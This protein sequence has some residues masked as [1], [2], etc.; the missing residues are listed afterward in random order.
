MLIRR[1]SAF[2]RHCQSRIWSKS[3]W[4]CSVFPW[5]ELTCLQFGHWS[6]MLSRCWRMMDQLRVLRMRLWSFLNQLY[7]LLGHWTERFLQS[8][9]KPVIVLEL[10]ENV[11]ARFECIFLLCLILG[12]L[13]AGKLNISA[14]MFTDY[15]F[16][17]K[18]VASSKQSSLIS[19]TDFLPL[20]KEL[21]A[22]LC[23]HH[24][25]KRRRRPAPVESSANHDWTVSAQ[26]ACQIRGSMPRPYI[27]HREGI[28]LC[29]ALLRQNTFPINVYM[30]RF[31]VCI[32]QDCGQGGYNGEHWASKL[33]CYLTIQSVQGIRR[34]GH[35]NALRIRAGKYFLHLVH[36]RLQPTLRTG[37]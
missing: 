30:G 3:L 19:K 7:F 13:W 17:K 2:Q 14:R 15:V 28:T 31:T 6:V 5:I 4:A 10:R 24:R 22:L 37:S 20:T 21:K 32:D 26:A 29:S 11:Q 33:T 12:G 23:R 34:I 16:P 18:I 27:F 25:P 9:L 1:A 36:T 35:P 8:C